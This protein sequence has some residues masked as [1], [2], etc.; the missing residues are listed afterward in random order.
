M[1]WTRDLLDR[2]LEVVGITL[3]REGKV[4][5]AIEVAKVERFVG[6]YLGMQV[7]SI[8]R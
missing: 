4:I 8:F 5:Q 3:V 6:M 2:L 1:Y 7:N